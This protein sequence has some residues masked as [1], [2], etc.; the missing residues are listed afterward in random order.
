[1][2][3]GKIAKQRSTMTAG[4]TISGPDRLSIRS[5]QLGR[6]TCRAGASVAVIRTSPRGNPGAAS[7]RAGLPALLRAD[8]GLVEG[9]LVVGADFL[10]QLVPAVVD[11]LDHRFL[12]D[13]PGQEA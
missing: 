10:V 12:V 6:P 8:R 2:I 1:M 9:E 5:A 4:R 13:L 3:S 7:C 11:R